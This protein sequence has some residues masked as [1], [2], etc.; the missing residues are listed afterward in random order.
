MIDRGSPLDS[1]CGVFSLTEIR[2]LMRIEFS[3]AQRYEYPL[4]CLLV[5]CDRLDALR[6]LYGYEA[7]AHLLDEVKNL[8]RRTTRSCD[9]LGQIADDRWLAIL[10]HTSAEGARTAATRILA[11]ARELDVRFGGSPRRITLSVGIACYEREN[12]LFFDTLVE[13]AE[14]ALTEARNAGGDR[15]VVREPARAAR[16]E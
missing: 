13:A 16:Q 7:R 10:P 12:T 5:A 2:H 1:A 9:Y 15:F 14:E 11:A 4:A 8:V 6:D 3:R